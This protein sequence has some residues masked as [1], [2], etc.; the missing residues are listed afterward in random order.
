[1][2]TFATQLAAF[3][4]L[5]LWLPA[6]HAQAPGAATAPLSL[7]AAGT[8]QD[9]EVTPAGAHALRCAT[10]CTV[11]VP[12]GRVDI[13]AH[14]AGQYDRSGS[15][16]VPPAGLRVFLHPGVSR[17]RYNLLRGFGW[18]L[19]VVGGAATVGL[20]GVA[21]Y[22]NLYGTDHS[23]EDIALL[24]T[25]VVTLAVGIPLVVVASAKRA[26]WLRWET[27]AAP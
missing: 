1:M 5:S 20:L 9:A 3:C 12:P 18:P 17:G 4:A 11:P 21:A 13:T 15:L 19:I 16:V 23:R 14:V 7:I 6:V 10:P 26:L 8:V 24:S 22:D 2:R 25:A 27:P